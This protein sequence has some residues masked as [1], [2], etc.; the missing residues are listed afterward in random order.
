M[1]GCNAVAKVHVAPT[2]KPEVLNF[3]VFKGNRKK[4][5]SAHHTDFGV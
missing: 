4:G 2:S 5:K 3:K 1:A